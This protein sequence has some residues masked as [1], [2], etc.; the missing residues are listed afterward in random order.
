MAKRPL[1]HDRL[2]LVMRHVMPLVPVRQLQ[3]RTVAADDGTRKLGLGSGVD[4]DGSRG[5][6]ATAE[7]Y[8]VRRR[9]HAVPDPLRTSGGSAITFYENHAKRLSHAE[10]AR[11]LLAATQNGTLSTIHHE[12]GW[13]YGSVLNFVTEELPVSEGG[14]RLLTFVS[15]LAEHSANMSKDPRA[16][17]LVSA[18]QGSGDRLAVAR[19]TFQVEVIKVD[20]TVGA[21]EAFLAAHPGAQYVHYDDFLCLELR[22]CSIRYI[23]GF[24]EMSWVDGDDFSRAEAD[25]VA[26]DTAAATAAVEHCNADHADAVLEMAQAL[27]GLHEAKKATM[28]TVDRYGFDVLCEMPDGLRRSRVEFSQRLDSGDSLR[29]AMVDTTQRAR[30]LL[31]DG[32]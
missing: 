10:K 31:A 2:A 21:K 32:G 23:G 25:P 28:L 15:K 24:G 16:S 1:A 12:T 30:R 13:P 20:K 27:S 22:V 19:A 3:T 29:K 9:G 18:T 8:K 26:I 4:G 14:P 7:L 11:T 5:G 17:L 6:G